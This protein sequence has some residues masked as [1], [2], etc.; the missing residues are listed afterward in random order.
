ML[1]SS[2]TLP[3]L[4]M[5]MTPPSLVLPLLLTPVRLWRLQMPRRNKRLSQ[6][7][8]KHHPP[9]YIVEGYV[10]NH[11][12][13]F[14]HLL[15]CPDVVI[16]II[17]GTAQ[18]GVAFQTGH[19]ADQVGVAVQA[20]DLQLN[21]ILIITNTAITIDGQDLHNTPRL[22]ERIPFHF[23]LSGTRR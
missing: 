23:L 14:Q 11:L 9:Q 6:F 4:P 20:A 3:P 15:H 1:G 5:P 16:T 8:A 22:S 19:A 12:E 2:T 13:G 7:V 18:A 17:I 10:P 21:I